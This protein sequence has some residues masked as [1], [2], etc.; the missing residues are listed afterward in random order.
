MEVFWYCLAK[1]SLI[2]LKLPINY[3]K[4]NSMQQ[5]SVAFNYCK[6]LLIANL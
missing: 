4:Y 6:F 2:F 1:K 3:G 5:T